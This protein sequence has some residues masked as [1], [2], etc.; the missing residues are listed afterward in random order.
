MSKLPRSITLNTTPERITNVTIKE[1][2]YEN[3]YTPNTVLAFRYCEINWD[4]LIH[5]LSD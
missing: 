5:F 1:M 2:N 4:M 3:G